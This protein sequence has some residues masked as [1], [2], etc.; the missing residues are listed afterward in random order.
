MSKKCPHGK[1]E[2][3]GT[4]RTEKGINYYYKCLKCGDVL[5]LSNEGILYKVPRAK[6]SSSDSSL[7]NVRK[8]L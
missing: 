4:E 3:L 2:L 8:K 1:V 7:Y 6:R 5:I